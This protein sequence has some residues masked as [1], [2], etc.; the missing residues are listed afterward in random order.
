[1]EFMHKEMTALH[2]IDN[3][4]KMIVTKWVGEATD[5]SLLSALKKYQAEIQIDTR[6]IGYNEI[7]DFRDVPTFQISI[8]GLKN[9]GRVASKNDQHRPRTRLAFIVSANLSVNLVKLYAAYRNFGKAPK[10]YIRAFK[11]EAEAY[12]WAG[13]NE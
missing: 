6:Y 13:N 1:M 9:I 7:V 8:K 12:K 10:K 5:D 11:N 4:E 2:H 3:Q